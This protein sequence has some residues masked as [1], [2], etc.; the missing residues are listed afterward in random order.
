MTKKKPNGYWKVEEHVLA[1]AIQAMNDQEW[2][3][4]PSDAQLKQHGYSSLSIAIPKYHGG[5]NAFRTK[6]GQQNPDTKPD[7]Y[8][9]SLENT[10]TEAKQAMREQGWVTLPPQKEFRK[11]GYNSLI[12]AMSKYHGG[13][14][15]FRTIL[16]QTNTKKPHGYWQKLENVMIETIQAM[17]KHNWDTLPSSDNL[18]KHGYSSLRSAICKYHGGLN[19]FR[20]ALGQ[21]NIKKPN[22]YWHSLDNTLLEARQVMQLYRL[23]TV[24]PSHVLRT[25]GYSAL[26]LAVSKYHGGIRHFRK[27]VTEHTTGKTQK[28]QLE[29]LLDEYI[30]A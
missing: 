14:Q 26:A 1:E 23:G 29:E 11:H 6:L 20:T 27:L 21:K 25:L 22:G 13:I 3:A 30:A 10:L 15:T 5:M 19:K 4:L 18:V 7:G 17:Q 24:P 2:D 12:A 8:W 16:G 28:Q 9:E